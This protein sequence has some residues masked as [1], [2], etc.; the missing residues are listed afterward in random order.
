MK[1]LIRAVN[2]QT[3]GS[4]SQIASDVSNYGAAVGFCGFIYYCDTVKFSEKNRV[5][6]RAALKEIADQLGMNWLEV[7]TSFQCLR[8]TSADEIEE[9]V[10]DSESEHYQQVQNALAW[11][12][13]EEA[14]R[15][16]V[17]HKK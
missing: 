11:F 13:L 4:L 8:G 12:A 5:I 7:I 2:K 15:F 3:G 10:F 9:G 6:I 16:I 14:A 1:N 17:D